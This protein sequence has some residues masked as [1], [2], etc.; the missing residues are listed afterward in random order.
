MGGTLQH[1][2]GHATRGKLRRTGK[3]CDAGSDDCYDRSIQRWLPFLRRH[4]P[5]Q[6]Q[7]VQPL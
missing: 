1:L 7:R 3:A 6:V 2:D 5:D 4:D